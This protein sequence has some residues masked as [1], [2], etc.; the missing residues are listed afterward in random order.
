MEE[1]P[2]VHIEEWLK[3]LKRQDGKTPLARTSKSKVRNIMSAICSHAIRYG[4]MKYNP[5]RAVRQSAKAMKPRAVLSPEELQA[6]FLEL[7][8]HERLLVLLDVPTGLRVSELLALQW[9]DIDF[10]EKT[11]NICKSIWHQHVGPVKTEESERLMP[12]EDAMIADLLAWRAESL[13]ASDAD[14]IFASERMRGRQPLWPENLMKN[15]IR[16][17]AK[18]AGITKHL[19]WH[20]FRHTFSTL[21]MRNREDVKT[22][23]SLMRHSNPG[24]TLGLYTHVIDATKRQ[25][26]SR[27]VQMIQPSPIPNLPIQSAGNA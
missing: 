1:G 18:R 12:L 17:A 19:S 7:E 22:V 8:L 26:Q 25:A 20:V 2:A 23:Q 10:G 27:V 9:S 14:W 13:Y 11:V 4:W 16:K 24:I 5:I 3:T 21:L 6:L 15:H